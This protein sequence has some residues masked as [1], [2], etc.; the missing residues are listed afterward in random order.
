MRLGPAVEHRNASEYRLEFYGK[1]TLDFWSLDKP[2]VARGRQYQRVIID[3]AAIVPELENAWEAVLRPTL[4]DLHGDA[5]FLS[6]PQGYNYFHT[7]WSY[8]QDM[9]KPDWQSWQM[10]STARPSLDPDEIAAARADNDPV[11]FAQEYLADFTQR[12]GMVL[13]AFTRAGNV[14]VVEDNHSEV[15]VGL[16]FNVDP[17]SAVVWSKAADE[18]HVWDTI[19]LRNS[20]TE[21]MCAEIR[22]R[23]PSREIVIYPDPTGVARKTAAPVGQTDFTIIKRAGFQ[24]RAPASPTPVADRINETN[25][26]LCNQAGRR[27]LLIHPKCKRLITAIERLA[28]KPD[29]SVIDKTEGYDH[30][31]LAAGTLVETAHGPMPIETMPSAGRVRVH[32]GTWADYENAQCTGRNQETIKLQ[33]SDGSELVCTPEHPVLTQR[34][35]MPAVACEG[36]ACYSWLCAT[37]SSAIPS[38]SLT[39][40]GF[41]GAG[42]TFAGALATRA[43]CCIASCGR[44]IAEQFRLAMRYITSTA[45]APTMPSAISSSWSE[46]STKGTTQRHQN[47]VLLRE[48]TSSEL[49]RRLR[50]GTEAPLVGAGISSI[51]SA[52]RTSS[53]PN[54]LARATN[55]ASCF[56]LTVWRRCGSVLHG[57]R[58]RHG[59]RLAS[60]MRHSVALD[61]VRL[62]EQINTVGADSV[63]DP[64]QPLRNIKRVVSITPAGK[65][66]VYNL[67]VPSA[68]CFALS[69]GLV[70]SNCD[71]LGYAVHVEWPI[72]N[73]GGTARVRGI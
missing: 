36:L 6:T 11:I 26:L 35:W 65:R 32:D 52:L 5:W 57:A 40:A 49:L 51:T 61:A 59:A 24:L 73:R 44:R 46:V 67:T 55:A 33:L 23:Y 66:D 13:F 47:A 7:L 31:C 63:A 48:R 12:A 3:E 34:G 18:M 71:A 38:K 69:N 28:Y 53:T 42:N 8:G 50:R 25:A 1:G 19:E 60:M 30:L 29:S 22:R 70:V 10:P 16:D 58:R 64:A 14:Q 20:G 41:I 43:F 56:L 15:R 27:R 72:A 9:D 54:V 62:F 2:D 68:G 45:I 21:E 17:M 37:Q 4:V 39:A